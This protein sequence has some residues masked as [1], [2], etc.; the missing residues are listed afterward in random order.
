MA[1]YT[2][3]TWSN[4]DIITAANLNQLEDGVED[5]SK[6]GTLVVNAIDDGDGNFHL[7][8][9]WQEIYDAFPNVYLYY[10]ARS[11]K[12]L[13][14]RLYYDE[15]NYV[16]NSLIPFYAASPTDYPSTVEPSGGN[17]HIK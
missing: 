15:T 17:G 4:G 6:G 5:V 14:S 10:A 12:E 9:T 11:D 7:N 2:A 16:I 8:K 1:E 13:I 3:R